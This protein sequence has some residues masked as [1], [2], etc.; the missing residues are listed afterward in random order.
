[1]RENPTSL[2]ANNKGADQLLHLRSLISSIFIYFLKKMV[3]KLAPCEISI[4]K[5][6]SIAEQADFSLTRLVRKIGF[7]ELW[8]IY[9]PAH[10]TLVLIPHA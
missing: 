6:V 5:L 2:H 10:M 1:M 8:S 4:L 7:L 9:G 3:V